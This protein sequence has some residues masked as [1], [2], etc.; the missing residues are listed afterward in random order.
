MVTLVAQDDG[1]VLGTI[2]GEELEVLRSQL[3][4]E[5]S[6]DTDYYV[7]RDTLDLLRDAG[8]SAGLLRMLEDAIGEGEGAD[9]AWIRE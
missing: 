4:E 8:A 7:S 1:R 9:V 2:S 5:D 3:E 6:E